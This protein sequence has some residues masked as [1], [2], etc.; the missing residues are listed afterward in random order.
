MDLADDGT[1]C[2]QSMLAYP[3]QLY[4]R[5]QETFIV[6]QFELL[7]CS[8]TTTETLERQVSEVLSRLSPHPTLLTLTVGANDFGWSDVFAFAQHLCTPDDQTFHAWLE[9]ITRTVEDHLVEQLVRLLP[10]ALAVV[11][12]HLRRHTIRVLEGP[13]PVPPTP[14]VGTGGPPGRTYG[15]TGGV[16]GVEVT[17]VI[18]DALDLAGLGPEVVGVFADGANVC[19]YATEGDWENAGLSVASLILGI[20]GLGILIE[21]IIKI[22]KTAV[23]KRGVKFAKERIAAAFKGGQTAAKVLSASRKNLADFLKKVWNERDTIGRA[24]GKKRVNH[25]YQVAQ[26]PNKLTLLLKTIKTL[27]EKTNKIK[28]ERPS[29]STSITAGDFDHFDCE[30]FDMFNEIYLATIKDHIY[31]NVDA[32]SAPEVMHKV[33][34][35]TID[36]SKEFPGVPKA[37]L[38]LEDKIGLRSEGIVIYTQSK[39]AA[40]KVLEKVKQ[41]QIENPTS[42]KKSTPPMTEPASPGVSLGSE[43]IGSVGKISWLMCS[44]RAWCGMMVP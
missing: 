9:G 21:G 11:E 14:D 6:H 5:L 30:D 27:S 25:L 1:T 16:P 24:Q 15:G 35:D 37:K 34:K 28:A 44:H 22:F 31:L 41:Y 42:F 3:W 38:T 2:H 40:A 39:E 18:D 10:T 23:A 19:L 32:D 8:G 4:A 13:E 43:P 29:G 20:R 33:V 36:N 7:A 26:E 17:E 12:A